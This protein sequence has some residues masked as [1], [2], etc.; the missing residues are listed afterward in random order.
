MYYTVQS[1]WFTFLQLKLI[2]ANFYYFI[3]CG[4]VYNP[5]GSQSAVTNDIVTVLYYIYTQE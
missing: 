4:L 5:P 2:S 1:G 3:D